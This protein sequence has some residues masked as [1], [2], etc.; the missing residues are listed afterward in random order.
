[1]ATPST[2]A[3]RLRSARSMSIRGTIRHARSAFAFARTAAAP[4]AS[5][6]RCRRAGSDNTLAA[7]ASRPERLVVKIGL[8]PADIPAM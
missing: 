2:F 5:A 8:E 3:A 1:M 7:A 4:P 6:S